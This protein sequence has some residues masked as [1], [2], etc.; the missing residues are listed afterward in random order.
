MEYNFDEL[1]NRRGTGS[2]KWD[3][4]PKRT[5]LD[6][7]VIPMWVAD[8]DFQSPPQVIEALQQRITQGHFGYTADHPGLREVIVER[9]Q[10]LYNWEVEPEAIVYIPG[11]VS[12]LHISARIAGDDGDGVLMNTPVYFPF[13]SAPGAEQRFAQF[14]PLVNSHKNGFIHYEIDFERFEASITRQTKA[15]FLCNPHNPV[16]RVWT[17]E[18][19]SCI[20]E[21][22]ERHDLLIVSDEVHCDLLYDGHQH[23]P[24]ASLT[25]EIEQRTIT[26]MAASKTFN[27]PGLVCGYAVIPNP[28]LREAFEK[29]TWAVGHANILGFAATEA[30]YRH[31]QAWLDELLIYLKGNRDFAIEYIKKHMPEINI[32]QPEGTYLL[33]LDCRQLGIEG[34]IAD[35]FY[36]KARVALSEGAPFGPGGAGFVR[37]NFGCPRVQLAEALGRMKEALR[38]E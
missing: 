31:G 30:A 10:Q 23:I 1:L 4:N 32:T 14:N 33:W 5:A 24:T 11:I 29:R 2:V 7:D 19:L 21:I 20:A 3:Q 18:E 16:G 9:L 35:F 15:F 26:L 13:L 25:P 34:N 37:L 22:C 27:I 12:G 17:R 36:E 38:K 8:M 6:P 28:E